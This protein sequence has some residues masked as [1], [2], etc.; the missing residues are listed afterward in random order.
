M[1]SLTK[2]F[3]HFLIFVYPL[4][5]IPVP[6]QVWEMNKMALLIMGV[7]VILGIYVV[8]SLFLRRRLTITNSFISFIVGLFLVSALLSLLLSRDWYFSLVGMHGNL[9]GSFLSL[10]ALGIL[11][12]IMVSTFSRRDVRQAL[13]LF[14]TSTT[15]MMIVFLLSLL[16]PVRGAFGGN[17]PAGLSLAT[18]NLQQLGLFLA[19]M[20]LVC[21]SYT[22][23]VGK[24]LRSRLG[25]LLVGL[26]SLIS[27]LLISYTPAFYVLIFGFVGVFVVY[28]NRM[29]GDPD[30]TDSGQ[31][32]ANP[33][34]RRKQT[35]TRSFTLRNLSMALSLV[36]I[37][38]ITSF[39]FYQPFQGLSGSNVYVKTGESLSITRQTWANYP[40]TGTGLQT[41]LFDWSK[42]HSEN[43][44]QTSAWNAR[45][46]D[47]GNEW[48]NI[49]VEGGVLLLLAWA[50]LIF[51]V[52]FFGLLTLVM[53]RL[54]FDG[55]LCALILGQFGLVLASFIT[56]FGSLLW[57][58]FF[59]FLALTTALYVDRGV[60]KG[61]SKTL[62]V[63]TLPGI[64]A[65]L[66]GLGGVAVF[67]GM[68]VIL[69]AGVNVYRADIAY[70][71]GLRASEVQTQVS[72]LERAVNLNPFN[73]VYNQGL[74]QSRLGEVQSDAAN[75]RSSE[76]SGRDQQTQKRRQK[77]QDLRSKLK[78][79]QSVVSR[80][81]DLHPE[82][83]RAYELAGS[84]YVEAMTYRPGFEEKTILSAM[85]TAQKLDPVNPVHYNRKAE[86]Y[87]TQ[88]QQIK[89][90]KQRKQQARASGSGVLSEQSSDGLGEKGK[91][92]LSKAQKAVKKAISLK[93]GYA[94]AYRTYA[95]IYSLR[96]NEDKQ[97]AKLEEYRSYV[98][99]N[100]LV[101]DRDTYFALGRAYFNNGDTKKAERVFSQITEQFPNHVNALY[102]L[103]LIEEQR[104]N[105]QKARSYF[106][107]VK[108]I[109]QNDEQIDQKLKNL[110]QTTPSQ[111]E[112]SQS[113][114]GELPADT[115]QSSSSDG[116]FESSSGSTTNGDSSND[117][118][119][120][121]EGSRTTVE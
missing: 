85:D 70:G 37:A 120:S 78:N 68:F 36:G 11:F 74:V 95:R 106:E 32:S 54:P 76:E 79:A 57:F 61:Q 13:G 89:T 31:K 102:S 55:T 111:S 41:V 21:V 48:F 87:I 10:L 1:K 71:R 26:L 29:S 100:D 91:T 73:I 58:T 114:Q 108:E 9:A 49:A 8:E 6:A 104:S 112:D 47:L 38:L 7:A 92:A 12:W 118:F 3:V 98:E 43:L 65:S 16:G 72:S 40:I 19:V 94:T 110:G 15:M 44:N 4:F 62:N 81:A 84:F 14:A 63:N 77:L 20:T 80:V 52:V 105:L 28:F 83:V 25:Y 88:A 66:L 51:A 27:V 99:N 69:F 93:K 24:R 119:P 23:F 53:K 34:K 30:N 42:Y 115:E 97:V 50:L 64:Y 35:G 75:L 96:G 22:V 116:S 33:K 121:D 45:F 56:A 5:L 113:L 2:P 67:I 60:F 101:L 82:D 103:G 109:T 86:Y 59:L 17:I 90:Q 107:R 18:G 117:T 39:L 46:N